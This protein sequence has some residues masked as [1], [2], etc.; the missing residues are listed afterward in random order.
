MSKTVLFRTRIDARRKK[1]A[2]RILA[3]VGLT[4][5]QL[6]NMVFAQ[7]E[8]RGGVPFPVNATDDG[9]LPHIPNAETRAA[10]REK[11]VKRFRTADDFLADLRK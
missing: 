4:P 10:L 1:N 5:G 3:R 9:Y 7:V 11:S 6:V 8:L 2:E